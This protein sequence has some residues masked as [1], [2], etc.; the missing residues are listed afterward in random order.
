MVSI[1]CRQLHCP[2]TAA[3]ENYWSIILKAVVKKNIFLA[4]NWKLK[5][6]IKHS[7]IFTSNGCLLVWLKL[8]GFTPVFVN[9]YHCSV[10]R[11]RLNY[12][13]SPPPSNCIC[14]N[15]WVEEGRGKPDWKV[16]RWERSSTA[17]Q[18]ICQ[19]LM[20]GQP[21]MLPYKCYISDQHCR[22]PENSLQ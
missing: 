11:D 2:P 19:K 10:E 8:S 6:K 14:S 4:S 1:M 16:A 17:V 5:M 13:I 18:Y 9:P 12:F 3:L 7:R 21:K 15:V 22:S 20:T